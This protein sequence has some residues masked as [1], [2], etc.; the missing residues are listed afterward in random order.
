MR[1]YSYRE[2]DRS[3][4]YPDLLGP[5]S[6][7][8]DVFIVGFSTVL[9]DSFTNGYCNVKTWVREVKLLSKRIFHPK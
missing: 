3:G 8:A 7:T 9:P 6:T 2:A 1:P 4:Q 5:L